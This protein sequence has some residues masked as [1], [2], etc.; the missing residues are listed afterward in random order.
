MGID[1]VSKTSLTSI[2]CIFHL[3]I[4]SFL[5]TD[6]LFFIVSKTNRLF[7]TLVLA[8]FRCTFLIQYKNMYSELTRAI[9]TQG[10]QTDI[11]SQIHNRFRD[12]STTF[13]YNYIQNVRNDSIYIPN[14]RCNEQPLP[15]D[16]P[17]SGRLL[18]LDTYTSSFHHLET[19]PPET[20]PN[21][22]N[23]T[24]YSQTHP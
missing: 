9:S 14:I 3:N 20:L 12:T 5:T 7:K 24:S 19:E 17:V 11:M 8:D 4:L 6:E 23:S 13:S 1:A 10:I 2:P 16:A 22:C 15:F 21:G 18:E